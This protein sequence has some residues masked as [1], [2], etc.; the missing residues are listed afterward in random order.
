MRLLK[1]KIYVYII[2]TKL[3]EEYIFEECIVFNMRGG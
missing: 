2:I 3:W 1:K